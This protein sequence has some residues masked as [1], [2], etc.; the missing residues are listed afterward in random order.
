MSQKILQEGVFC[1]ILRSAR[2]GQSSLSDAMKAGCIPVFVVDGYVKPFSE[3][4]DWQR[5]SVTV[6]EED[7]GNLV[8]ILKKIS[9]TEIKLM[10]KKVTNNWVLSFYLNKLDTNVEHDNSDLGQVFL[11]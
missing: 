2:L 5:A 8:D 4:L 10:Q 6:R 1:L 11:G 9:V 7:L 3:V